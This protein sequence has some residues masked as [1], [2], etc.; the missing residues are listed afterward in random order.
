MLDKV[1]GFLSNAFVVL[2][3]SV[4]ACACIALPEDTDG[5]YAFCD[6]LRELYLLSVCT[7]F[8]C[9]GIVRNWNEMQEA[10]AKYEEAVAEFRAVTTT[11]DA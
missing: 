1:E 4:C 8:F 7:W 2:A 5:W 11:G 9:R 10:K 6:H 3:Y